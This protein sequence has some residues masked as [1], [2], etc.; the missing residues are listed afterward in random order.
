MFDFRY[1]ALSLTAVVVALVLGVLLGVAIG[2]RGLVS[3]GEKGIRSDL[4]HAIASSQHRAEELQGKLNGRKKVLDNV[5]PLLVDGRLARQDVG[6]VYL[7]PKSDAANG[8]ILDAVKTAGG[9]PAWQLAFKEP[10]DAEA[11]A[12]NAGSTRYAHLADDPTPDD[13]TLYS[14]LGER[15]GTQLVTGGPLLKHERASLSDSFDGQLTPVANIV[16]VRNPPKELDQLQKATVGAF[17][18]GVIRGLRKPGATAIGVQTDTATPSQID[19]YDQQGLTTV[20]DVNQVEGKI[21]LIY[22]LNGTQGNF[23]SGDVPNLPDG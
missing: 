7:G 12:A 22:A 11:I 21:S 13:P 10:L 16:V 8:A 2:D 19:W 1:H 17:E 23:G 20:S 9:H 15:I 5:F 6:I 14:A 18:K 3:S 4:R